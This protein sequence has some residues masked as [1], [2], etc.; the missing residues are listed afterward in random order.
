[1]GKLWP[2]PIPE[3]RSPSSTLDNKFKLG[4]RVNYRGAFSATSLLFV[5]LKIHLLPIQSNCNAIEA[6]RG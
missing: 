2:I 6:V 1:M 5:S 3:Y 4:R